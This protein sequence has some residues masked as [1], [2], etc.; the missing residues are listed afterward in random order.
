MYMYICICIYVYV[1]M[2]VYIYI[3]IYPHLCTAPHVPRQDTCA[4]ILR[5]PASN[6]IQPSLNHWVWLK[7]K[8]LGTGNH[9]FFPISSLYIKCQASVWYC[10]LIMANPTNM[11]METS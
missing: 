9:C 4:L 11:A 1:Y 5:S 8:G 2:Y 6:G 10:W 3:Y 7:K